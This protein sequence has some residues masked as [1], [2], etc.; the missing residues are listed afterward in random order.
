LEWD[1]TSDSQKDLLVLYFFEILPMVSQD[2]KKCFTKSFAKTAKIPVEAFLKKVN[3]SDEGYSIKVIHHYSDTW[4]ASANKVKKRA[5]ELAK[6][7]NADLETTD[8]TIWYKKAIAER[9]SSKSRKKGPIEGR[10]HLCS[11]KQDY[12]DKVKKAKEWL[13]NPTFKVTFENALLR[14][15]G[16]ES[17]DNNK[18][19]EETIPKR[20]PKKQ[21]VAV[22]LG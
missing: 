7:S 1:S 19:Y 2:W 6:E 8:M 20:R 17:F 5:Q 14:L 16:I 4:K 13:A 22:E 12:N 15:Y 9:K 11:D 18:V 3:G 10:A 21:R